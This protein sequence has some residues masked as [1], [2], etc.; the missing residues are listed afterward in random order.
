MK[1]ISPLNIK[2]V[3]ALSFIGLSL[4]S[5]VNVLAAPQPVSAP[6]TI[7]VIV[8]V[9]S[10][11][12]MVYPRN[13]QTLDL[14]GAYMFKVKPVAG[15]TGYL[16]GLFQDG[17]MIYENYRD[18]KRLSPDGTF[19]LRENDSNHAKFHTGPVKVMIRAYVNN[20]WTDAREI[21][22]T[23]KPRISLPIPTPNPTPI[24]IGNTAPIGIGTTN[25]IGIGTTNPIGIGTTNPIQR[26]T[27]TPSATISTASKPTKQVLPVWRR[28]FNRFFYRF[29][30][31]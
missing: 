22:I 20:R 26:V 10:A 13:G 8:P 27:A 12:E 16:F 25:P 7:P 30:Y 17:Q 3:L 31:R 5:P 23:L 28:F 11:P 1:I 24:G 14:E 18:T 19:A 2:K 15:A 6:I 21:T 29:F 9:L 4:L